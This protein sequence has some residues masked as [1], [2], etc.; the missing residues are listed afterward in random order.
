MRPARSAKRAS[1]DRRTHPDTATRQYA[2][3]RLRATPLAQPRPSRSST[4]L[5][6]SGTDRRH[7]R[8]ATVIV[9]RR[10]TARMPAEW[11]YINRI[12]RRLRRDDALPLFNNRVLL[13]G[14][15]EGCGQR[16]HSAPRCLQQRRLYRATS[17]PPPH[18]APTPAQTRKAAGACTASRIAH[19]SDATIR[20]TVLDHSPLPCLRAR[21]WTCSTSVWRLMARRAV[22]SRP[23]Q[24][25]W[26]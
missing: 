20:S 14:A 17:Y 1:T 11:S 26:R 21:L 13:Q 24:N 22:S 5:R 19:D 6:T 9:M 7:R 18:R 23:T 12:L 16:A 25:C 2:T 10:A 4:T 15:S 8:E 3:S